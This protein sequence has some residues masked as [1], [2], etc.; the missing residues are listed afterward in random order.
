M[1]NNLI[2]IYIYFLRKFPRERFSILLKKLKCFLV[3]DNILI[4]LYINIINYK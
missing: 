1:Y 4:L 3:N 2:Y